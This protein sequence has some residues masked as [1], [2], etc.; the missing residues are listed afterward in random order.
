M[1]TAV[2]FPLESENEIF[3]I[4]FSV[5]FFMVCIFGVAPC[6]LCSALVS[7]CCAFVF[8]GGFISGSV[9]VVD[10]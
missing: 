3:A 9:C 6:V 10:H 1:T 2:S 8:G 7:I 5:S 4:S